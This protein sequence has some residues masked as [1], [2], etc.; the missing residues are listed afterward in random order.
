MDKNKIITQKNS[1]IPRYAWI[2]LALM[3]IVNYIAYYVT[4]I[5]T[6]TLE[7]TDISTRLDDMLPVIP[8][9]IIVYIFAYIQWIIGYIIIARAG[10][11]ICHEIITGEIIAK[12]CCMLFFILLP[13]TL[14]RPHLAGNDIFERLTL[15]IYKIDAA[16]NLFPSIHCLES[17]IITRGTL[18]ITSLPLW[19]KAVTVFF[20][21]LVFA[22]TVLVKQHVIIDIV[23]AIAVAEL[24]L[25][26]VDFLEKRGYI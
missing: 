11:Q 21:I 12:I 6:Q 16:D 26:A 18:R 5:F 22:S 14:V 24:G 10:K 13:T 15:F 19:Y 20:T 23:G 7:H 3:L 2:P 17:Y 25:F 8:V 1:F 4:R 9:F